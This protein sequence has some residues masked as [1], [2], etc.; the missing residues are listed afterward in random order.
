MAEEN[1]D[2]TSNSLIRRVNFDIYYRALGEFIDSFSEIERY[3]HILLCQEAA[4][5]GIIGAAVFS[6]VRIDQAKD[7]I[8]RIRQAKNLPIDQ[9]LQRIFSQITVITKARNDIVHYGADFV[10]GGFIVSNLI[11]AHIPERKREFSANPQDLDDMTN[12]LKAIRCGISAY[13]LEDVMHVK[14][15][16]SREADDRLRKKINEYRK[17]TDA[18]WRYKP[19]QPSPAK[20]P[21]PDNLPK[22]TDPPAASPQL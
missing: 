18:P 3:V 15:V 22:Q 21:P 17:Y 4:V 19:P 16:R 14:D 1:P 8:N 2:A 6:G 10:D 5:N 12:D 7:L 13:M 20:K 9:D 11:A